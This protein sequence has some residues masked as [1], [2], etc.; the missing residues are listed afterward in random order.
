MVLFTEYP[1]LHDHIASLRASGGSIIC[2]I[3]GHR[4][5]GKTSL[6]DRLALHL[7]AKAIHTDGFRIPRREGQPYVD[8]LSLEELAGEFG[9]EGLILVEGICVGWTMKRLKLSVP[10]RLYCKRMTDAGLWADDT[11]NFLVDGVPDSGLSPF[12]QEVVRYHLESEPDAHAT[13]VY[14]WN[15]DAVAA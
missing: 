4:Q 12:D 3:D 7:Q 2:S 10:H 8:Q 13:V 1:D 5:S 9:T 11:L 15:G 6:A 14:A